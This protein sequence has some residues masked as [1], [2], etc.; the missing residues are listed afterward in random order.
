VPAWQARPPRHLRRLSVAVPLLATVAAAALWL[1]RGDD[2]R[3]LPERPTAA[4]A[5]ERTPMRALVVS[6]TPIRRTDSR[7]PR[8]VSGRRSDPTSIRRGG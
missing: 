1:G 2:V 8:A 5:S 7:R 3:A 6:A 4:I